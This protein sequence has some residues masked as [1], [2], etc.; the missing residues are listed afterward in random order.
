[1]LSLTPRV[2]P[3]L[4]PR[5]MG[6][7]DTYGTVDAIGIHDRDAATLHRGLVERLFGV[8][9][10]GVLHPVPR[11]RVNIAECLRSFKRQVVAYV[12]PTSCESRQSFCDTYTGRRKTIYTAAA[13][14]LEGKPVERRDAHSKDFVKCEKTNF[15]LKDDPAPR[16]IRPRNPRYNVEVGR[17]LKFIEH[18]VYSAIGRVFGETTV[19]KGLSPSRRARL[20]QLKWAS[21][22]DPVAVGLDMSRF[23]QHVD[24]DWLRWEH[25]LYNAIFRDQEL[26]ELLSWQ[27][28]NRG[29]CFCPDGLVRYVKRGTRGSGDMNTA[30]GNCTIMCAMIWRL[31]HERGIKIHLANDGDDCA[32]IIERRDLHAFMMNIREWFLGFGFTA[33][34]DYVT[35]VFERIEFCQS[36]PVYVDGVPAMVRNLCKALSGDTHSTKIRDERTARIHLGAMGVCGGVQSIGVPVMQEYYAALRRDGDVARAERVIRNDVEFGSYGFAR[37]A[38]L[39]DPWLVVHEGPISAETRV[40]F[41]RAFGVTPDQQVMIEKHLRSTKPN[42]TSRPPDQISHLVTQSRVTTWLKNF[43]RNGKEN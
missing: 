28:V 13:F 35:D 29:K 24:I 37:N 27:L 11:P 1:M 43:L 10:D 16:V 4:K 36:Q 2:A 7:V 9:R 18:K 33:K 8:V 38:I 5:L 30:L 17:R 12:G 32:V 40:S 26:A 14:S 15:T 25:S 6:R 22:N 41:W 3:L 19:C 31:G 21:C 23:D 20:L 39:E 42:F 34:V